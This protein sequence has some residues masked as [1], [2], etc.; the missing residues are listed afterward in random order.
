MSRCFTARMNRPGG[1]RAAVAGGNLAIDV[2]RK[3]IP[4]LG[5]VDHLVTINNNGGS[6]HVLAGDHV[7]EVDHVLTPETD[8]EDNG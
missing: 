5:E 7:L 6:R 4:P 2:D 8:H 3:W 1:V